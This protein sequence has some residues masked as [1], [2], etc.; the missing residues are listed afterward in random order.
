EGGERRP[1]PPPEGGPQDPAFVGAGPARRLFDSLPSR[2][3]PRERAGS[4]DRPP[5]EP[6]VV[7][8]AEPIPFDLAAY[9]ARIGVVGALAPTSALLDHTHHAP[10]TTIPVENLDIHLIRP[11]R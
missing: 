10:A 7:D 1:E 8:T 3:G 9:L 6:P 5:M 4:L 2:V 11:I